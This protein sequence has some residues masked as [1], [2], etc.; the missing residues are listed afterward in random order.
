MLDME[1]KH[2][3][4]GSGGVAR[5]SLI[6]LAS[7][8]LVAATVALAVVALPREA[9]SSAGRADAAKAPAS[10]LAQ[11]TTQPAPTQSLPGGASSLQETYEDW[12]GAC[13]RQAAGN[14]CALSQQQVDQQS[15][16]RLVAIEL[17]ISGAKANGMLVL[18]FGLS[19][20]KGIA[21]KIDDGAADGPLRFRTCLPAGCL[22]PV[23]FD[24]RALGG[25]RKGTAIKLKAVADGGQ[26][27]PLSISLKGFAAALDRVVALAR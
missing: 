20:E 5:A 9:S 19:L 7:A 25:L 15:R 17:T 22:V 16:P 23:S 14:R 4:I 3:R 24:A 26:D 12:Q 27:L 2:R 18:P 11:A 1:G 6:G 21:W 8:C 13:V 10:Q